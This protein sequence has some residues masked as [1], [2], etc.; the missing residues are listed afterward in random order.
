MN[1][2]ELSKLI[3]GPIATVP[4]P[5][6]D[7]YE[8]DFGRM[9]DLTQQWVDEGIVKGKGVIKIAGGDGRRPDA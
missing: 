3:V 4:T 7:D 5:F 8:V 6:D 2:E 1:R 9:H